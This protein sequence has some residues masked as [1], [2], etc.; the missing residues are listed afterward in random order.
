MACINAAFVGNG[1]GIGRLGDQDIIMKR[2]FRWVMSILYCSGQRLVPASFVKTAARPSVTIEEIEINFLNAKTWI[3]GKASWETIT[4]TYYDVNAT[5]NTEL[6]SWLASV[7]DFTDPTCLHMNS[8]RQDYA[9]QGILH[10]LDGCGNIM[11]QWVLDDMWP[12]SINF[13]D[14]SYDTSE[15]CEIELTLRYSQVQYTSFCG[16]TISPCV[17]T[18]C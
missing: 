10:I 8:K 18:A 7:Y 12:T 11:E 9:G 3:P 1:M 17:C 5:E 4:V 14:L 6:L 16:G 13:G 15:V 2:K